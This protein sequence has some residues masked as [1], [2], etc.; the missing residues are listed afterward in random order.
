MPSNL[1][2]PE[3]LAALPARIGDVIDLRAASQPDHHALIDH[4]GGWTYRI[5]SDTISAARDW[6]AEAGIRAGD[7]VMIVSENCRAAVAVFFAVTGI[8]AWPVMIN[9]RLSAREVDAIRTHC[10]AR[11]IIYA[12]PLSLLV[13]EHAERLG[14][15]PVDVAGLGHVGLGP[16][17]VTA[18]PE[19]IEGRGPDRVAAL[20]YTSGS[21]GL[22]KGVMLTHRNLLFMASVAGA[23]RSLTPDDR[24]YGVLPISHIV[25]LSVVTLG[26]L[27][28]GASLY[29]AARFNPADALRSLEREG[30]TIMLGTP[31][32]F[33]LMA[34]YA[35]RK[36]LTAIAAPR[37]RI[38]SSSGAPL[39]P[40]I[41]R[42]A[43]RLFDLPLHNGYGITECSPTIAQIRPELPRD[44]CSVGPPLP[45]VE[46]QLRGAQTADAVGE[47]W[48]R[49]PNVMKGYYADAAS[50]AAV[51]TS[52]GWFNTQ[53][54]ARF[55]DGN[56]FIVGRTRDLII[57]FG[58]NVYP[59]E[60]EAVFNAHPSVRHSAVVARPAE[61]GNEDIVAFVEL[62]P[63]E[64]IGSDE[65]RKHATAQLVSYKQPS[66]V[67]ILASLPTTA[68]GKILKRDLLSLIPS[69]PTA[70]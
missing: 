43:E 33:A 11:R 47:L 60:I 25:G 2:L 15:E 38:I 18:I 65:L 50:T 54:L 5:L 42:I 45:G 59:A 17:N 26:T 34:E 49:G 44:D 28:A 70:A 41:K 6:L 3:I 4:D 23:V 64:S 58:F 67:I 53:D 48:V 40:E 52:D 69:L 39:D 24:L 8:G 62:K 14:S 35:G 56:L 37:L 16:L 36:G 51:L 61:N 20:V 29:F 46:T 63:G 55:E 22:P 1:Y 10:G 57:R 21:T 31:A 27:L 19:A 68:G 30:I 66:E 32:M 13:R 9:P 7:R 12:S